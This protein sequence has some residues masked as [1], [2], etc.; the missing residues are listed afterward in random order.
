[1]LFR[2]IMLFGILANPLCVSAWGQISHRG[3]A[4]IVVHEQVAVTNMKVT[5]GDIADIVCNDAALKK[6]LQSVDIADIMPGEHFASI[7]TSFIEIRLRLA[8]VHSN[9]FNVT[10]GD[11]CQMELVQPQLLTDRDVE[12]AAMK[13]FQQALGTPSEDLRVRLTAPFVNSLPTG[14]K[15]R[16]GLR[17][18]VAMPLRERLGQV[19][20]MVRLW[21]D[22][23]LVATRSTRFDVL[24][25]QTVAVTL[26]SLRKEQP[27]SENNI[28]LETRFVD[29]VVDEP[30]PEDLFARVS[31]KNMRPGELVS[32]ND[33]KTTA[34]ITRPIVVN[35]RDTVEVVAIKGRLRVKLRTAQALQ[36]G[37]VGDIIQFK[38][39]DSA[40]IRSGRIVGPG[41][42]EIKI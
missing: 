17:V 38:N 10:G 39:V 14:I 7:S 40:S 5:L 33:L 36:S 25:R 19:S 3:F 13:T 30:T 2:Y 34:A 20:T 41:S 11:V 29:T 1:M 8:G 6:Q 18:E 42:I 16:S 4:R 35:S 12:D 21:K 37:R 28:R 15:Q 24:K 23:E 9:Q 27:I 32:P 22:D 26:V 31:N